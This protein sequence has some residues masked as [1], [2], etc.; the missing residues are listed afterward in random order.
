META[1]NPL[2]DA[3]LELPAD[4]RSQL[5]TLLNRL[6]ADYAN[7]ISM[8][9]EAHWN[10][11]G[12]Q[13]YSLHKLFEELYGSLQ[14]EVDTLA[15]RISILGGFA[16]GS[17][18]RQAALSSLEELPEFPEGEYGYLDALIERYA[19]VAKLFSEG[20][21]VA[22]DLDDPNTEDLLTGISRTLDKSLW[23]LQ[24]HRR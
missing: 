18:R 17:L 3:R 1:T 2:F 10:V 13:F 7:L 14:G 23:F 5:V 22:G 12:P 21:G 24:A 11:R 6:L 20:V 16:S 19:T 8:T 9:L 4:S 15:E